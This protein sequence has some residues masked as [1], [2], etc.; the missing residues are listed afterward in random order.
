MF[1]W[2]TVWQLWQNKC[3]PHCK[4]GNVMTV[5]LLW[6]PDMVVWMEIAF[7]PDTSAVNSRKSIQTYSMAGFVIFLVFRYSFS[8]LPFAKQTFGIFI[9]NEAVSVL[10]IP[11]YIKMQKL[12]VID[13]GCVSTCDDEWCMWTSILSWAAV[14]C[15]QWVICSSHVDQIPFEVPS[16][17]SDM[18]SWNSK[19]AMEL[20]RLIRC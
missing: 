8:F 12:F 2:L 15:Y 16:L 9:M 6:S 14:E 18:R 20:H 10:W 1:Q 19:A 3:I 13:C 5:I 7:C 4:L 17:N 11:I